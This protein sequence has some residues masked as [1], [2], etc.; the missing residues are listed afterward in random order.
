[1]LIVDIRPNYWESLEAWVDSDAEK[2]AERHALLEEHRA[3]IAR[4]TEKMVL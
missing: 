4:V 1:M 3:R 2:Q